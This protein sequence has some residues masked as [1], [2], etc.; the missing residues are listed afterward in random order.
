LLKAADI[1][2]MGEEELLTG[3]FADFVA[4]Q[5]ADSVM[6]IGELHLEG[7]LLEQKY[8]MGLEELN[9]ALE[10]LENLPNYEKVK[11][12]GIPVLEAVAD[13]KFLNEEVQDETLIEC[14]RRVVGPAGAHSAGCR[15]CSHLWGS[16]ERHRLCA[17]GLSVIYRD[18]HAATLS[19]AGNADA[20]CPPSNAAALSAAGNANATWSTGHAHAAA[21]SAAGNTHYSTDTGTPLHFRGSPCA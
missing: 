18:V 8:E 21:L 13:T 3:M 6:K 7:Q 15:P 11:T 17:S 5:I 2:G 10:G 4:G 12:R 1:L 14:W 16:A 20:T 19:A 9:E